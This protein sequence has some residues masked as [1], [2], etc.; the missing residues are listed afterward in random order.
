[1]N[2][3]M[4]DH[5]QGGSEHGRKTRRIYVAHA[6]HMLWCLLLLC[7][8]LLPLSPQYGFTALMQAARTRFLA[9]VLLLVGHGADLDI[10]DK[11]NRTV[12]DLGNQQVLQA[13]EK[14]KRELRRKY[15]SNFAQ[16]RGLS[17]LHPDTLNIIAN[18]L[19]M[20]V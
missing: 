5:A 18:Y 2:Q 3:H 4:M 14:G 1:M 9:A 12:Y 20:N 11:K 15:I 16:D 6:D 13:I 7:S 19:V 8:L 10:K 17:Q